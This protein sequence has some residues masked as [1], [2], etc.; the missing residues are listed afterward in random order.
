[1]CGTDQINL[2]LLHWACPGSFC[3]AHCHSSHSCSCCAQHLKGS[4]VSILHFTGNG[5]M[6]HLFSY[7]SARKNCCQLV[8]AFNTSFDNR[9]NKH[10]KI[11]PAVSSGEISFWHA[12]WSVTL[13]ATVTQS[14]GKSLTTWWGAS[15]I[16][17]HHSKQP[18]FAQ[19]W[20]VRTF[21]FT[22]QIPEALN[23]LEN[24]HTSEYIH[25]LLRNG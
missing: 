6:F 11:S 4:S 2:C 20:D 7:F 19:F 5:M 12:V 14:Y 15:A 24:K 18:K 8:S 16:C 1:M 17:S 22:A 10:P 21:S 3:W 25:P 23:I 13:H 9:G